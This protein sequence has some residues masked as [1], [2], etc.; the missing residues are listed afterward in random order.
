MIETLFLQILN[1]SFT[2]GIVI[3]FV[4]VIRLFLKKAPK[5]FSYALWAVVLFRLICPFSFESMISLLPT[6]ANPISQDILNS[7]VPDTGAAGLYPAAALPAAA[8]LASVDLWQIWVYI[9]SIIWIG[10]IAVLLISSLI[11]LWKLKKRL[12]SAVHE[13]ENIYFTD[14]LSTPFVMGIFRPKIY[15]PA[16]LSAKEK[17]YSLLHEQTHI[18][19]RDPFV[20]MISFFVLCLHWFNPLAWAA[21]F[22]SSKD[23]EMSCDEAVIKLLGYHI[24]KEY[25]SLLLT[26]AAG[27]K[28]IGGTPLAFGGGDTKGRIN[29]VLNYKKSAFW[30]IALA[31]AAVAVLSFGL[32]ANPK[33]SLAQKT[34]SEK[35]YENRT[36]YLGDNAAVGAI[37]SELGFPKDLNYDGFELFTAKPPYGITI[38]FNA[39]TNALPSNG[40][41]LNETAFQTNAITMFSLIENVQQ[42]TF[43]LDDGANPYSIDYTRTWAEDYMEEN[44]LFQR[45]KTMEEFEAFT[46]EIPAAASKYPPYLQSLTVKEQTQTMEI[47]R[48]YFTKE[49]PYYEGVVS[50]K[51]ASDDFHL[52]QNTGIEG[53]YP[54]GNII[55][56]M[57]LTGKDE[58]DGNPLRSISIARKDRDADWKIINQGF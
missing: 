19:R 49:A 42:I 40:G 18:R 32:M 1:M 48:D 53:D 37:I 24:K 46:R 41:V 10:G 57:V 7:P 45:S 56:Y 2:A 26:L 23:M 44:D 36:P 9:G 11:S 38:H 58:K 43:L 27:R 5:I 22:I 8:P 17:Q 14:G 13:K 29:N 20:K 6:K 54:A 51:A 16:N 35:L 4:L 33:V 55:I 28:A 52:Y 47:A 12:R 30:V 39:D 21:F 50:I 25:S 34:E 3:L 31:L 15:L